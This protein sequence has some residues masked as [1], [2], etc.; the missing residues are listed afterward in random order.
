MCSW[1]DCAAPIS[2]VSP[3]IPL[4]VSTAAPAASSAA[5]MA[6]F[7]NSAATW[8]GESMPLPLTGGTP[9][10]APAVSSGATS[11]R[12]PSLA[13]AWSAVSPRWLD[14]ATSASHQ[15]QGD[16]G[17]AAAVGRP[18]RL[19]GT[20]R[21]SGTSWRLGRGRKVRCSR[22][23]TW[24]SGQPPKHRTLRAAPTARAPLRRNRQGLTP[25]RLPAAQERAR[26]LGRLSCR[27]CAA[28][29]GGGG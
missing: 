22:A 1:P 14:S 24:T 5:T 26:H 29:G 8:R 2:G 19:L 17:P 15:R 23:E 13:A 25:D 27:H 11:G 4:R 18:R 7:P 3:L 20:P 21:R 28:R 10:G 9:R 12:W 6:T 16:G